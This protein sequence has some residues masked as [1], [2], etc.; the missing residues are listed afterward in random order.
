MKETII[1]LLH[2]QKNKKIIIQELQN[3]YE[4]VLDKV[5]DKNLLISEQNDKFVENFK[6]ENKQL[7]QSIKNID[8][9]FDL[10]IKE[11]KDLKQYIKSKTEDYESNLHDIVNKLHSE[12]KFFN[13]HNAS[14]QSSMKK[15]TN[16]NRSLSNNAFKNYEKSSTNYKE[17]PLSN[18]GG[19]DNI[20]HT[21][22]TDSNRNKI[23]RKGDDSKDF[24]IFDSNVNSPKIELTEYCNQVFKIINFRMR[25]NA[26]M[27]IK[28]WIMRL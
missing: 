2:N 15:S 14:N 22:G 13:E 18:N 26:V 7:K 19:S 1:D 24:D 21:E 23:I 8:K 5:E 6:N 20:V 9:K 3:I 25:R 16:N 28:N 12:I 10:I 11:N 17:S 4:L 27:V